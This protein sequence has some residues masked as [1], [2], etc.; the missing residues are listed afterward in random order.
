[1]EELAVMLRK[2]VVFESSCLANEQYEVQLMFKVIE[3]VDRDRD[4]EAFIHAH[5]VPFP[6]ADVSNTLQ[7]LGLSLSSPLPAPPPPYEGAA[8]TITNTA[9]CHSS[10]FDSSVLDRGDLPNL[11]SPYPHVVP[12][13]T[14]LCLLRGGLSSSRTPTPPL[15]P[16]PS[17]LSSLRIAKK[18]SPFPSI[19][20]LSMT[21]TPSSKSTSPL[22]LVSSSAPTSSSISSR[23]IVF[24]P[25]SDDP[26]NSP[27][28]TSAEASRTVKPPTGSVRMQS[29]HFPLH[30]GAFDTLKS[31]LD[32][33]EDEDEDED[34]GFSSQHDKPTA[35]GIVETDIRRNDAPSSLL[36]LKEVRT[37]D[38]GVEYRL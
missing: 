20:S 29:N 31:G 30:L 12:A 36:P 15:P 19:C 18:L 2:Q 6:G 24:P 25:P 7:S 16:F 13:T 9:P 4:L 32:D 37:A 11:S 3:A 10:S 23:T 1:M 14:V 35:V 8:S 27:A 22:H 34:K 28:P 38:G 33:S 17:T 5:N 21:S 26:S